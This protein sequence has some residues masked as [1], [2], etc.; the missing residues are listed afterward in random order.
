MQTLP[1]L[2]EKEMGYSLYPPLQPVQS[3]YSTFVLS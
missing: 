2:P 1:V 3:V